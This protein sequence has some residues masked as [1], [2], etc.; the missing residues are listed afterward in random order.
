MSN[1]DPDLFVQS[2]V[3]GEMSTQ[4]VPIPEGEFPLRAH[5][6][7]GRLSKNDN[8]ILDITWI[9]EDDS[10][11][12]ET[13][14]DEPKVRQSIFLDVNEGGMLDLGK[15]KNVQLGRLREALGQNNGGAWSPNMIVGNM[16]MGLVTQRLVTTDSEGNELPEAEHKVFN[17]VK[18]VTP[19]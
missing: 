8:A 11:K 15:G 13:G 18:G 12:E 2:T 19:L 10:V 5:E 14:M 6:V 1:F 7:K 4:Y 16:V 3:E 17:D 9:V